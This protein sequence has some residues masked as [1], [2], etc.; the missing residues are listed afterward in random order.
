[1]W[2][3]PAAYLP[4]LGW[5]FDAYAF[6]NRENHR[7]FRRWLA[8]RRLAGPVPLSVRPDRV[9]RVSLLELAHERQPSEDPPARDDF[10]LISHESARVSDADLA[11]MLATGEREQ[12]HVVYADEYVCGDN[13]PERPFFKPG[14]SPDLL[15]EEDYIGP[16]ILVRAWILDQLSGTACATGEDKVFRL[17]LMAARAGWV[18]CHAQGAW[19][20]WDHPRST[21]LEG[22][23]KRARDD[24]LR[25]IY[26]GRCGHATAA[27][28][29]ASIVIPTRDRVDLLSVCIESMYQY[30]GSAEFEVI[31]IDN[32]SREA[33]TLQWLN[34]AA[35]RYERLTVVKADEPFNWSR[36]NNLGRRHARG[37]VGV[38]LN[39][40]I[41]IVSDDW[42][43]TLVNNA[44]RP[45]IGVVGA[46]MFY[47]NGTIQH[48]GIVVGLGGFADHVYSGT[49]AIP[50]NGHMFVDP[51]LSRNVLCC[52][53]ACLGIEFRKFDQLG[54]FDEELTITGDVELCLRSYRSG[55]WN[56]YQSKIRLIHRESAT[57]GRRPL[58]DEEIERLWP[59]VE[60][61]VLHGDPFY[62]SQLARRG[63]YPTYID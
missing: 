42:I 30:A 14:F 61:F 59:S 21:M 16:T 50:D 8:A 2:W 20:A 18:V 5:C 22:A 31:V 17:L 33:R 15:R 63:R 55:Y 25:V 28:P 7:R 49:P 56:L 58:P 62:N 13:G 1:M 41:E 39:N 6:E 48:A 51:F 57:R 19:V 26:S 53:G 34:H 3:K 10:V 4:L 32:G 46:M 24:D 40:D 60:E 35:K 45:E 11:L 54:G 43:E 37:Q 36:L 27:R 12:A 29:D 9:S 47:P 52:T 38:F 23:K 44:V